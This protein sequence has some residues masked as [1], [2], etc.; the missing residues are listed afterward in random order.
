[1]AAKSRTPAELWKQICA[2][3][4]EAKA[5]WEKLDKLRQRLVRM[6]KMGRKIKIIIPLDDA[7][8][9]QITNKFKE[10][11]KEGTHQIWAGGYAREFAFKEVTLDD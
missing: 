5:K 4:P 8:G 11:H 9:L 1:M 10:A 7:K 2:L 3:E 6:A